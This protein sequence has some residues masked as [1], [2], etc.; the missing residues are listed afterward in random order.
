[1]KIIITGATGSLGAFLTR[2]FS[3]SG[4]AVIATGKM[5]EPPPR[6]RQFATYIQADICQP[7][8]LPEADVCIHTAA[9]SHDDAPEQAYYL[10]NIAGTAHVAKAT[11]SCPKFIHISSSSVYLPNPQPITE[12][13]AGVQG[14]IR[15]S[16]YGQSKLQSEEIL[17]QNSMHPACFILRPRALYGVG[18]KQILPRLLKLVVNDKI[19]RLGDMKVNA[20]MTHY[21][22]MA[23]AIE[24]C[25]DSE[26]KGLSIYNVADDQPY[27]LIEVLRKLTREIY[28]EPLPEREI[29]IWFL[30]LISALHI[31]NFS[32]LLIRSLTQDMVLDTSKIKSDLHYQSKV[33]FEDT[34][35]EIGNWVKHIGGPEVLKTGDK[36]LAWE[37]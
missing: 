31:K 27:V 21:Q 4:H 26:R 25:I 35:T 2:H 3:L 8:E 12:D 34:M 37:I 13:M 18:D 1:M 32:K 15:L 10:P 7:F 20:S 28:G 6:L 29:P 16:N 24:C 30:K 9:L 5:T 17:Q 33:Q 36:R 22:N 23:H 19:Q 11:S 14:K